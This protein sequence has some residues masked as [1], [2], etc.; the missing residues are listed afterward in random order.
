MSITNEQVA[1]LREGDVVE[2]S[3]PPVSGHAEVT[4]TVSGPLRLS[5]GMLFVG[6]Y[7]VRDQRG[8][9]VYGEK[10]TLTVVSRVPR[11]YVNHPRTEPVPGDRVR[12][13]DD[14]SNTTVWHYAD[15]DEQRWM[16]HVPGSRVELDELP[17]RL[18]LLIDGETGQVVPASG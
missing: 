10:R 17:A 12:D 2:L 18:C 16:T 8:H 9:P 11:L 5:S 13:A 6:C 1:D 7:C 14:D 4:I 3:W 15:A